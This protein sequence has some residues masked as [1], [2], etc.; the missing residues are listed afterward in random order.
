VKEF[1][2][3]VDNQLFEQAQMTYKNERFVQNVGRVYVVGG[4]YNGKEREHGSPHFKLIKNDG[5]ELRI[6]IPQQPIND[7][8][9]ENITILDDKE[10]DRKSKDILLDWLKSKSIH[11]KNYSN[12]DRTNIENLASI[13]NILNADDNNVQEI[14]MDIYGKL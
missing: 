12:L 4:G 1:K 6:I 10:L 3:F 9:I 7:L 14:D 5:N 8:T 11:A 13:W 2:T